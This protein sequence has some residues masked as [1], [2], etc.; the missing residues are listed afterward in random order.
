MNQAIQPPEGISNHCWKKNENTK[1]LSYVG[2]SQI[3]VLGL[4]FCRLIC[5][6]V[7]ELMLHYLYKYFSCLVCFITFS[8]IK[9]VAHVN[10]P[11]PRYYSY[12][13][14][15][16]L[17]NGISCLSCKLAELIVEFTV[18]LNNTF[19]QSPNTRRHKNQVLLITQY[20]P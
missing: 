15:I 16:N 11:F 17:Y 10:S 18:Y 9:R 4:N 20:H 8:N 13:I 3:K 12:P 1:T 19:H 5:L 6:L 7:S 14:I 2:T